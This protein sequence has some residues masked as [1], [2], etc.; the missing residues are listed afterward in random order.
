MAV[1]AAHTTVS[2][3]LTSRLAD[4]SLVR[5]AVWLDGQWA[6][7]DDG[8]LVPV[9]NPATGQWLGSVPAVGARET[10]RA[11]MAAAHAFVSWRELTPDARARPLRRW[12]ELMR[13]SAADLST[14]M[15]LEQGK[16]LS[17]A[18]GEIEYAASFIDWFAEEGRRAYGE[19]IPSH[20]AGKRLLTVR[21]PIGVCGAITPWNFPSAMITR[22]AAAALAAGCP[23]IV[24]PAN[25]TPFSAIALAALAERAGIPGGVFQVLSGD[26]VAI[27]AELTSNT[28]VRALSFTGSTEVG[29]LLLRASADTVKRVSLEL[30]GHA[31]FIVFDDID[32]DAAACLAVNAKFQTSGQDCLAANRILVHRSIFEPFVS[33]F[34][35]LTQALRVGNGLDPGVTIG[36]LI[37]DRAVARCAAQVKDAVAHGARCILGGQPHTGGALFV[38]P[39]VLSDVTPTMR[40]WR[41]ETFGPVA[42]LTAFDTEAE[43]ITLANDTTYGLAAYVCSRDLSR[44]LRV[45]EQLEY[46]MVAVNTDSFTGPPIPFGGVKQSGLGREGSRHGLDEYTEIKYLCLAVDA[47]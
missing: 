44:V 18:Q 19:T 40:I 43:A 14:I 30:G 45:S 7:A 17:E 32:V 33:K 41:E 37:S 34:A 4:S 42:A 2:P 23:M 6:A 8:G 28:T 15:T 27:A 39:T 13:E 10:Q 26:A 35:E 11:V 12:A 25:E 47:A 20:R 1:L 29:K 9:R 31:P 21:A 22:K 46:G 3:L 5:S 16:P 24:K 36:P 38:A